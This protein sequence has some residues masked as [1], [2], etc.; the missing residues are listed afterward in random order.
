MAAIAGDTE[1]RMVIEQMLEAVNVGDRDRVRTLLAQRPDA[2]HIGTDPDEWM[3]S[4]E[5]VATL[6]G[7]ETLSAKAV[8]D[9]ITVHTE[10]SEVAW[11]VGHVH[12][13]SGSRSSRPVRMTD[14]LARNGDRW[15]IVHSHYSIG[16][17]NSELFG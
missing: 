1:I 8:L 6:G 11:A 5:V 14:V 9:D 3:T 4:E 10:S 12:F 7:V 15:T 13:Q 16:V 17:P 2:L